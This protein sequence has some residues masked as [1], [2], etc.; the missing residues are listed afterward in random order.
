MVYSICFLLVFDLLFILF[1][2][3]EWPS[4]GKELTPWPFTLAVFSS[5]E[6]KAHKV[7]L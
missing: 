3:A 1:R 7:S 2:I 6:P 4:A 5:P